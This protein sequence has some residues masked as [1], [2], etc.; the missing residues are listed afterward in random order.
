MSLRQL[1][2]T[3]LEVVGTRAYDLI[4]LNIANPD[5]VGHTG[6]YSAALAALEVVDEV[7]GRLVEAFQPQGSLIITS[8]HGN[9]EAMFDQTGAVLTAHTTNPVLC[10]LIP[11][12]GTTEFALKGSG[13]L[14][15]IAPTVLDLL[16]LPQPD[17]ML[18]NSL[19]QKNGQTN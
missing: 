12:H 16:A 1:E 18:G 8:D 6:V 10:T 15:D 7:L 3:L 5:M 17:A 4:L 14:A 2:K 13:I 9:I 11:E 19:I